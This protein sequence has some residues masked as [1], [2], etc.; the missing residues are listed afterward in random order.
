MVTKIV[1]ITP[2]FFACFIGLEIK[3][4]PLSFAIFFFANPLD[5]PLAGIIHITSL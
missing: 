1:P 3:G 2:D 4:S 5:P